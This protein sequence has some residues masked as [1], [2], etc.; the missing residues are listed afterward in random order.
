MDNTNPAP[1]GEPQD[2]S[3]TRDPSQTQDLGCTRFLP[4]GPSSRRWALRLGAGLTLAAVLAGVGVLAVDGLSGGPSPAAAAGGPAVVLAG[5]PGAAGVAAQL[6]AILGPADSPA[7]AAAASFG[8]AGPPP[9]APLAG[10][11]LRVT[12]RLRAARH[13]RAA[14]VVGR[15]CHRRGARLAGAE[16]GQFTFQTKSGAR[17][18]AFERGTIQSASTSSVTVRAIDGTTQTWNLTSSTVIR[19]AGQKVSA[20][21]LADGD[22][23]FIGGPVTN[24]TRDARLAV[25]GRIQ[26]RPGATGSSASGS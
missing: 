19:R 12:K 21:R 6:S 13:P 22:Q 16:Y 14:T 7:A 26:V 25:I 15:A 8:V 2:P 10:A 18:I 1:A 24:G 5:P 11:C 4:A 9:G 3:P 20:S 17:T 23:V